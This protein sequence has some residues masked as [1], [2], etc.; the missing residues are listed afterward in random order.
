MYQQPRRAKRLYFDVIPRAVDDYLTFL[1]KYHAEAPAQRLE[2]PA[3]HIHGGEPPA[4]GVPLTFGVLLNLVGVAHA[5]SKEVLWGFISRY[6]PGTT[7]ENAPTLDRLAGYA[8]RYYEDFV[9]PRQRPRAPTDLER[10]AL[11]D[12]VRTLESLPPDADATGIQNAIYEIGKRHPFP[13]LRDWLRALYE[14][15]FGQREGPRMGS[16]VLLFGVAETI[17]LVRGALGRNDHPPEAEAVAGAD[18]AR[19]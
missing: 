4:A 15:L 19:G 11:S 7:P 3:W 6:A 16:F 18:G 2:N 14:V 17:A 10:A 9:K 13:Q 1:E 5:E 8:I 12:L